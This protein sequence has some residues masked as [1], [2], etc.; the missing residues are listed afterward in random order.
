[1]IKRIW[2]MIL[3]H[4]KNNIKT[5][6]ALTLA[7]IIGLSAGAFTVNGLST[8]QR[9]ELVNY[10]KG[11]LQLINGQ[12]IDSGELLKASLY[13]N[14]KI[15]AV[16]WILGVTII[17]I[18]FIYLIIGIRG[19]I[20]GFTSGFIIEAIGYKGIIFTLL[21]L[22]PK[23]ILIIPCILALGVNGINFSLDI[24]KNKS[25]KHISKENLRTSLLAYCFVTLF[26]SGLI[27]PGI[28]TEAYITP[29][30]I[31]LIAPVIIK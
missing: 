13:D 21:A 1:M 17:G 14:I 16:L 5:Y 25:I 9:E 18:P 30:I 11:F 2:S 8:V 15:I 4:V 24:I 23:E 10:F 6:F 19:F 31:K 22:L 12:S 20:T 26:Y 29:T 27:I 28:L 3:N 7:F